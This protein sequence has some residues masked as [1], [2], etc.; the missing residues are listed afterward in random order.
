MICENCYIC[1]HSY[2]VNT[3]LSI[4]TFTNIAIAILI[5]IAIFVNVSML[6]Y[7]FI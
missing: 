1:I 7:V 6:R 3:Y 5:A 2:K 4:L